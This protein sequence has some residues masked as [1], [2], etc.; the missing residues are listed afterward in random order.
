MTSVYQYAQR[1]KDFSLS[2]KALTEVDI[3]ILNELVYFPIEQF[4]Q[5]QEDSSDGI[6]LEDFYL[7]IEPRLP[8]LMKENWVLTSAARIKLLEMIYQTK[9]YRDIYLFGFE[10]EL[11]RI[12]EFQFAAL[13]LKLPTKEVLI[14]YR[15]TDDTLIGWKEDCKMAY[16]TLIP[17]Q[18]LAAHYLSRI[19]P[20]VKG[21]K[22]YVSGH[23]KGGNLAIYA[24]AFQAEAVQQSIQLI[25][26]FDGP[27][28]HQATLDSDGYKKIQDKIHHYVPEDAIVGMMLFHSQAPIVIKSRRLGFS[29]HIVTNWCIDEDMLHRIEKRSDF[30]Y[31]VDATLKEWAIDRTESELEKVFNA[32]FN[33]IF[34]TGIQSVIEIRKNPLQFGRMFLN[35]LH[36]VDPELRAF[37]DDNLSAFFTILRSHLLEQRRDHYHQMSLTINQWITDLSL[38]QKLTVESSL[39]K[40]I[41]QH[42][43]SKES[44][45]E[46]QTENDE[47][48]N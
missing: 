17:S 16:Q 19:F 15:G 13:S 20:L 38:T 28:F 27:G 8:L 7:L 33:L 9:R 23:S 14:S 4:V 12:D 21:A 37:L 34:E 24:A 22:L 36:L 41:K 18:P 1:N 26:S 47:S 5:V 46:S 10:S 2:E 42:F 40:S 31:L 29:H 6:R 45:D 35:H 32:S 11:E 48:S 39:L 25:L 44:S 43:K 30:S 3:L